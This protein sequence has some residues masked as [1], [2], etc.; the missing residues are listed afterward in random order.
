MQQNTVEL[1]QGH[2]DYH[3]SFKI[4]LPVLDLCM[5][6]SHIMSLMITDPL[7]W[8]L[9][10]VYFLR[11]VGVLGSVLSVN[12]I[13]SRLYLFFPYLMDAYFIFKNNV[14]KSQ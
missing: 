2:V 4:S 7:K 9:Y 11:V 6:Y 8:V 5:R 14:K 13:L 10:A 12:V 3:L 1:L